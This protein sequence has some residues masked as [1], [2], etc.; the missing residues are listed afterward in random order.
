MSDLFNAL[1]NALLVFLA[2]IALVLAA[3]CIALRERNERAAYLEG[4][5]GLD[6]ATAL[7]L[8]SEGGVK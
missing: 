2:L 5:Y 1:Y 7:R 8:A 6:A 3:R 4:R